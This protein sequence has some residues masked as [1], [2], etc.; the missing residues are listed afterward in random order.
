MKVVQRAKEAIRQRLVYSFGFTYPQANAELE[1][2]LVNGLLRTRDSYATVR[3]VGA[4]KTLTRAERLDIHKWS[5]A[6]M[7]EVS[8]GVI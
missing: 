7:E 1:F 3:R 8:L 6:I 5:V 4:T 2:L